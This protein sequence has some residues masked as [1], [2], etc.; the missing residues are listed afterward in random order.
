MCQAF[1]TQFQTP[2]HWGSHL[3]LPQSNTE[4]AKQARCVA[5]MAVIARLFTDIIFQPTHLISSQGE[6]KQL[7]VRQARSH[8]SKEASFRASLLALLPDEQEM[9]SSVVINTACTQIMAAVS[10]LLSHDG[11]ARFRKVLQ[12]I[13][14]DASDV[15]REVCSLEE[16]VEL[17]FELSHYTDWNWRHLSFQSGL[18]QM[19]ELHPYP[20]VGVDEA[21][22]VVFPRAFSIS[23]PQEDYP[24]THGALLMASQTVKAREEVECLRSNRGHGRIMSFLD[25]PTR[26]RRLSARQNSTGDGPSD[27]P[28][29]HASSG[30]S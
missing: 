26:P 1:Q 12:D 20:A 3:P 24:E 25:R 23:D 7:L 16:C 6:M 15:W 19:P 14:E 22:F 13:A 27:T 29:L 30:T 28:F 9:A 17:S 10:G 4:A 18:L 11:R 5:V 8:P 2:G 21:L